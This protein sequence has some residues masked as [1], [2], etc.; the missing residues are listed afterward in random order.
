MQTFI[1]AIIVFG[2]IVFVHELGHFLAARL[3]GIRVEEFALGMGPKVLGK[4]VG[5]TLY[6][7]RLLP[8][9]GFCRMAGEVGNEE[10]AEAEVYD[11]G[12]FD[13]K[14]V[15]SRMAVVV[16]GPLLN[17]VLAILLFSMIFSFLGIP[18]DYDTFVGEIVANSPAENA[19]LLADDK[20]IGINGTGVETWSEMSDLINQD[21][22]QTL[23]VQFERDGETKTVQLTPQLDTETGRYLIGIL[24]KG[25]Y[26]W[27]KIGFL[28]GIKEG[29]VRTWQVIVMTLQGL[30][31]MLRGTVSTDGITG[32][33]GI[34]T[35]IG[36]SARFGLINLIN[37]T[38][39]ISINLGLLNLLPI[40]A[41]D[42]SRFLFMVIEAVRGRPVSPA[43]ENLVH[44]IGFALLMCLML[45][46]TYKDFIRLF[47]SR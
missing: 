9:G 6:S 17:F 39:V 26:I 21:S 29:V 25:N 38:A 2:L 14:P 20:I 34:I 30:L 42:G 10:Y 11:P 44:L 28:E 23:T 1:A 5:T 18:Q 47:T 27:Q 41:L 22:G 4:K 46:V 43:K 19:G 33:V 32:P 24:P 36:E 12:R 35:L 31:G 3:V 37:L 8:L 13:H 7:L 45:L 15:W 16:A 40:P